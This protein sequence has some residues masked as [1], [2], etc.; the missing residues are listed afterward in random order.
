MHVKARKVKGC[1]RK[2]NKALAI[3]LS[4]DDLAWS[5]NPVLPIQPL[6]IDDNTE[7]SIQCTIPDTAI[8][9]PFTAD[10]PTD[11]T[12]LPTHICHPPVKNDLSVI[13]EQRVE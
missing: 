12:V 11:N 1:R 5:G 9:T 13:H 7:M 10:N 6:S 4:I 3:S 2:K 8:S